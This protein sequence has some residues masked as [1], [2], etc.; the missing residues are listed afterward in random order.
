ML[1]GYIGGSVQ[2]FFQKT[3]VLVLF[4]FLF[5]LMALSFFGLY[6]IKMPARFEERIANLSRYQKSG[7]ISEW[8]SWDLWGH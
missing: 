3:W 6:Q 7:I 2:A 5:V 8:R 1:V 4:S